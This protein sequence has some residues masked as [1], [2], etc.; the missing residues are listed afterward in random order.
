MF[1]AKTD[2]YPVGGILFSAVDLPENDGWLLCDGRQLDQSN[3]PELYE[4][5]Q[6]IYSKNAQ[7]VQFNLPNYAGQFLRGSLN[8]QVGAQ[9]EYTT[10]KPG[11]KPFRATVGHLPIKSHVTHGET[12]SGHTGPGNNNPYKQNT[13]TSGGDKETR[14]KNIY[15][16]M[17]IKCRS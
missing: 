3:Y 11:D 4:A 2:Q 10:K 5:I 12:V 8:E 14:P 15:L 16:K 17:Y 6:D 1:R 13:C 9:Q 7:P